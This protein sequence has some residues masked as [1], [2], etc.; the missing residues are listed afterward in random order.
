M[1]EPMRLPTQDGKQVFAVK[2]TTGVRYVL[3]SNFTEAENRVSNYVNG[4][5][6]GEQVIANSAMLTI[7]VII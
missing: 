3:A 2:T 6:D 5:I 7:D 1:R 4:F